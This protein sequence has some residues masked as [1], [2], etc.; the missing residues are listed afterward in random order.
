MEFL[1]SKPEGK[2]FM[3]ETHGARN[4]KQHALWWVLCTMVGAALEKTRYEMSD[5]ALITLG[6][7]RTYVTPG[8][9]EY[10]KVDSIAWESMEQE[11]FNNVFQSAVN[12]FA[13]WLGCTSK[14][15]MDQ[16]N[17]MVADKRY[18]GMRR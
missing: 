12:V 13:G 10:V 2:P 15:V 16:F 11:I 3:A 1:L 14:E 18:T 7:C 4:P 9:H 8:G 6:R 5:A 17:A